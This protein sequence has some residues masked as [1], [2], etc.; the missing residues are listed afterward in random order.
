MTTEELKLNALIAFDG[1]HP[2]AGNPMLY[3]D[4]QLT[5]GNNIR[6]GWWGSRIGWQFYPVGDY[7]RRAISWGHDPAYHPIAWKNLDQ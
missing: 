4:V 5:D 3:T 6:Y 7:D 1:W 2:I